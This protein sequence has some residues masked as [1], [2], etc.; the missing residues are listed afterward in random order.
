MP[1]FLQVQ[2]VNA[3]NL[4]ALVKL[5]PGTGQSGFNFFR[6]RTRGKYILA[7]LGSWETLDRE[8]VNTPRRVAHFI[9]QGLIET[10]WLN[11]AVESL[12][13][14][15]EGL[16][17]TFS[18]YRN[19]PDLARQHAGKEQ[20]IGETAY[21]GRMGNSEPGDGFKYRGRGFFQ[22][23]G[24]D[25]YRKFS[26]VSGTDLLTDPDCLARDLKLSVAVAAA[27]WRANGLNAYA[28][29]NNAAAVSRGVNRGDP[30]SAGRAHDEDKRIVWTNRVIELFRDPVGVVA[31]DAAAALTVGSRGPRVAALQADLFALGFEC[32]GS[33]DGIFG[34][35]TRLGVIGAQDRAGMPLTG[36]ADAAT[37]A[38]VEELRD[39]P[40]SSPLNSMSVAG[41]EGYV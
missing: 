14:K 41:A 1:R 2:D 8:G 32:V 10:G 19:N 36:V 13:Y 3:I 31:P 23:T 21:G 18:A 30:K 11:Y 26:D 22:I 37:L 27:Y 33:A 15:A 17:G 12:K 34:K 28:D 7:M 16:I 6:T 38:A 4:D 40:R 39:D 24:K 25:N 35:D 29:A 5:L 9:G 20:L